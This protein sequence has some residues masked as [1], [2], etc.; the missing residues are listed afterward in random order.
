MTDN[1]EHPRVTI[2]DVEAAIGSVHYFTGADGYAGALVMTPEFAALPENERVVAPP[3]PLE[4]LTFC[5]IVLKNGFTVTGKSACVSPENFS[6]EK[7]QQIAHAD[8]V[9]KIWELLGFALK[10]KLTKG[11]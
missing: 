7:G 5:V 11:A 9:D 10:D 6:I 1:T 4:L 8:A 2:E 3:P